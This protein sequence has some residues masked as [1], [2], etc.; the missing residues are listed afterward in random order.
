[1]TTESSY[2]YD[3]GSIKIP[4]GTARDS[5]EIFQL[6]DGR[7]AI[8]KGLTAAAST[9][10]VDAATEGVFDIA[11]ATGT[12]F[13]DGEPVF[14]DISANL[15]VVYGSADVPNGDFLVGPAAGAKAGTGLTVRVDINAPLLTAAAAQKAV[16]TT[17]ATNSSPY[18]FASAAQADDMVAT[19]NALRLALIKA[20]IIKGAA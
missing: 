3:D 19:I 12:T 4:A 18:G 10:P 20:G 5:G 7:A 15:A 9:D 17:G 8:N 13:L 6:A 14:W 1:M 16:A 11:C 2:A